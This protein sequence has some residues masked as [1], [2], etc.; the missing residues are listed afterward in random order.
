MSFPTSS[1]ERKRSTL[2]DVIEVVDP[3]TG[4]TSVLK[5]NATATVAPTSAPTKNASNRE[6]NARFVRAEREAVKL[7]LQVVGDP[8]IAAKTVVEVR[9]ISPLL[10]G[11]YYITEAKH[12][13]S[14]S[15]YV[16]DL[17]LKRDGKG[18]A[19]GGGSGGASAQGT[20]PQTGDHNSST[21]KEAGKKKEVEKV[22]P[23]TG[24]TY[25]EYQ[26]DANGS[27]DPEARP[28]KGGK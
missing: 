12:S 17:K 22:N 2:A 7:S 23:E 18:K 1:E 14:S 11:K 25:T 5:R 28:S 21:P 4:T 9:G 10:S 13:V 16:C 15:G 24:E 3:K 19:S 27:S 8:T 26:D 20:K 6:A